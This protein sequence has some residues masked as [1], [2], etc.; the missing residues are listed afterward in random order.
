MKDPPHFTEEKTGLERGGD[1]LAHTKGGSL[2]AAPG[3][4][5]LDPQTDARSTILHTQIVSSNAPLV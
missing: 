1:S 5:S 3:N 4:S 2:G